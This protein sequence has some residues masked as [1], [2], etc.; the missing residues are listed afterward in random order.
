MFTCECCFLLLTPNTGL[1]FTLRFVPSSTE[2]TVS[3][4]RGWRHRARVHPEGTGRAPPA[5]GTR[6]VILHCW[7]HHFHPAACSQLQPETA[8][9]EST[10]S[11][12]IT[13]H[14]F[15]LMDKV[16]NLTNINTIIYLNYV[17]VVF[18]HPVCLMLH[19]QVQ[20]NL[21]VVSGA[22]VVKL[23]PGH[24]CLYNLAVTPWRR[25]K[26]TGFHLF[27]FIYSLQLSHTYTFIKS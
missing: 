14:L 13:L 9:S 3:T 1:C 8:D 7:D 17:F 21:S 15:I 26:Q 23:K 12:F 22:P 24:R 27:N 18:L 6:G 5:C 20:T 19:M 2:Q 10:N 11:Q 25:G 4:Q 16:V